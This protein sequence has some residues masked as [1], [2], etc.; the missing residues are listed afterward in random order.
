MIDHCTQSNEGIILPMQH[1]TEKR[2]QQARIHYRDNET[3]EHGE[4]EWERNN[5]TK[6][7]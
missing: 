1:T 2:I 3:N 4:M 6:Q 7:L 5:S